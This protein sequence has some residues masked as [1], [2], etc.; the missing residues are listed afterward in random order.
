MHNLG[1][2]AHVDFGKGMLVVGFD[3]EL[4]FGESRIRMDIGH[5]FFTVFFQTGNR[6]VQSLWRNDDSSSDVVF[7]TKEVMFLAVCL[8]ILDGGIAIVKQDAVVVVFHND[9]PVS[10]RVFGII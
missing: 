1:L 2:H 6:A 7:D 9:S 3:F 5:V 4:G 10:S 8:R